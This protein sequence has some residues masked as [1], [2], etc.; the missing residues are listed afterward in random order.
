[1]FFEEKQVFPYYSQK[2]E[3]SFFYRLCV[4]VCVCVFP[5]E[6]QSDDCFILMLPPGPD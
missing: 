1:M 4:P 5:P 6:W 3:F 2:W